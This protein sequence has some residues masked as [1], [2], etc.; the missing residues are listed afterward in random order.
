MMPTD[1]KDFLGNQAGL[2]RMTTLFRQPGLRTLLLHLNAGERIPEHQ[3]RGAIVVHCLDGKGAF[4]VGTDRA[5]LQPGSLISVPP[6]AAH[7]VCA[8]EDE[9]LLLL[10]SVS[11]QIAA[12]R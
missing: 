9:Q 3:T 10:V 6:N 7:S 8:A 5:E 1:L 2:P 4:F 11:E 12:E